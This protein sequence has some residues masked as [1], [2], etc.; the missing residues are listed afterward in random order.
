[1][2]RTSSRSHAHAPVVPLRHGPASRPRI[3]LAEVQGALALDLDSVALRA[4]DLTSD[5]AAERRDGSAAPVVPIS[6]A[7]EL[8]RQRHLQGEVWAQRYLQAA[9][10]IAGGARPPSQLVRWSTR[11][12]HEDLRRRAVLVAR[13]AGAQAGQHRPHPARP[14][15]VSVRSSVIRHGVLETW[16]H[17][18]Y[19]E[20]SRAVA[21]RFE[22]RQGRWC[23]TALEF[24]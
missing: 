9:V 14:H 10:E 4:P 21:A 13:A 11:S 8:A 23:C 17:V 15:L 16:A 19:G 24:A 2:T 7:G 22:L 5:G 3:G 1:M 6:Q 20:R 12:V 18:R